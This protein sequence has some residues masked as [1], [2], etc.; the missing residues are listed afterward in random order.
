VIFPESIYIFV[1]EISHFSAG[2]H[3]I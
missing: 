1:Y 2:Y 3:H